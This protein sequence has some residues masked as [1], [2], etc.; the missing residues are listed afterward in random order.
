MFLVNSALSVFAKNYPLPTF[1]SKMGVPCTPNHPLESLLSA[2]SCHPALCI[3]KFQICD[4]LSPFPIFGSNVCAL[5]IYQE[6]LE[7]LKTEFAE[8][9]HVI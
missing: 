3:S 9:W 6:V 1:L 7:A 4:A 8:V 5:Q 2:T